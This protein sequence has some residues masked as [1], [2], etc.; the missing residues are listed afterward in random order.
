MDL[1]GG[2]N[3]SLTATGQFNIGNYSNKYSQ[4]ASAANNYKKGFGNKKIQFYNSSRKNFSI[5]SATLRN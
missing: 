1:R 4:F 5:G 3:N 2:R